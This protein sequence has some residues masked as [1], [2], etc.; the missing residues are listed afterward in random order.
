MFR[1]DRQPCPYITCV[2]AVVRVRPANRSTRMLPH[3]ALVVA[4]I[5]FNSHVH[6][7]HRAI[8][9]INLITRLGPAIVAAATRQHLLSAFINHLIVIV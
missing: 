8:E 5:I 3:S 6:T 4:T 2:S 9:N 7:G 1:V